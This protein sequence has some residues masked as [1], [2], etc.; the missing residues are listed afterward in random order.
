MTVETAGFTTNLS[1]ALQATVS[2]GGHEVEILRIPRVTATQ[3]V[4]SSGGKYASPVQYHSIEQAGPVSFRLSLIAGSSI[5]E[6]HDATVAVG[7]EPKPASCPVRNVSP[8]GKGRV[9]RAP[10]T[11]AA[12]LLVFPPNGGGSG[13][14]AVLNMTVTTAANHPV[15]EIAPTYVLNDVAVLTLRPP[16]GTSSE[17]IGAIPWPRLVLNADAAVPAEGDAV[18]AAGFG[19]V[20]D[21]GFPSDGALFVDQ[22]A[23]TPREAAAY[24]RD[25]QDPRN[26]PN[27]RD[28]PIPPGEALDHPA[29]LCTAVW[30]GDCSTCQGDSGGPLYQVVP[31]KKDTPRR[32]PTY[33]QVGVTSYGE[34]CGRPDTVD[35]TVRVSTMKK[36][37]EWQMRAAPGGTA[38]AKRA[39]SSPGRSVSA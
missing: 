21:A 13:V 12:R 19:L 24:K 34:G 22:P 16:E 10:P 18:R 2:R 4:P 33:V 31:P 7:M 36:W 25:V 30:E 1:W 8:G 11:T 26:Y 39:A 29:L 20:V 27:G 32:E 3:E 15:Y 5:A 17:A 37:I 38:G 28:G 6:C 14:P 9:V 23:L 35:V